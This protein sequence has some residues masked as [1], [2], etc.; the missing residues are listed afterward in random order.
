MLITQ[1]HQKKLDTLT[2]S[3]NTGRVTKEKL[4]KLH[5][6]AFATN[7]NK[8]KQNLGPLGHKKSTHNNSWK[9]HFNL[10]LFYQIPVKLE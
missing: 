5:G 3:I 10:F 1:L 7:S 6:V 2:G 8:T 4:L 9:M